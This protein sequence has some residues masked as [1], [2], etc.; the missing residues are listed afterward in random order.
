MVTD[1]RL[2]PHLKCL[3]LS[4][5][6]PFNRTVYYHKLKPCNVSY[7]EDT[8]PTSDIQVCCCDLQVN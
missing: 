4:D 5:L 8:P 1:F 6:V 3:G 2:Y 7:S